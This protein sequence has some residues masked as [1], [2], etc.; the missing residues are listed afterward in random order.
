MP[1]A[2]CLCVCV[3]REIFQKLNNETDHCNQEI[4]DGVIYFLSSCIFSVF[5]C[6]ASFRKL[7]F[8]PLSFVY[9]WSWNQG[10]GCLQCQRCTRTKCRCL[11]QSPIARTTTTTMCPLNEMKSCFR[12]VLNHF[13]INLT[14]VLNDKITICNTNHNVSDCFFLL[15]ALYDVSESRQS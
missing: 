15:S 10:C 9:F 7:T 13:K 2:L 14:K 4:S 12:F 5:V 11:K 6:I 8:I 3:R 1:E